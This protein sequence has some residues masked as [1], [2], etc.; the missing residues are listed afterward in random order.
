MCP[1]HAYPRIL[2]NPVGGILGRMA[3]A[4]STQW[5]MLAL[6]G[7]V[8][9]VS[10]IGFLTLRPLGPPASDAMT[11]Q[12]I[13]DGAC[14]ACPETRDPVCAVFDGRVRE[15]ENACLA[16]CDDARILLMDSCV[17]IPRAG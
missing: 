9:V 14:R 2:N 10:I 17:A 8:L 1:E 5:H 16:A 6:L 11:G 15:Y 12:V 3:D 7:M 4:D 13:R